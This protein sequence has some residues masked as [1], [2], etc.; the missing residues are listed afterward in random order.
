[1]EELIE[2]IETAIA[3]QAF[4]SEYDVPTM[5]HNDRVLVDLCECMGATDQ[6]G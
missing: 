2:Q 4:C 1:M 5:P 6:G 3:Y